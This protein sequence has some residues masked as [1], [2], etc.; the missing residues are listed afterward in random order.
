MGDFRVEVLGTGNHGC[1]RDRKSG[2]KVYGCGNINCADCI[3]AEYI[4]K[5]KRA[6][7]IIKSAKLIHWPEQPNTV[8]D[9]FLPEEVGNLAPRIRHG[10]F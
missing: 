7:T 3:T 8:S 6:G 2:E 9:L 5:L 4:A 1:N 10:N